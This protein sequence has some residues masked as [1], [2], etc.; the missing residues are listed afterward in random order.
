MTKDAVI[1]VLLITSLVAVMVGVVSHVR[2]VREGGQKGFR[3]APAQELS[4]SGMKAKRN[5]MIGY[6]IFASGITALL[7]ISALW[8]PGGT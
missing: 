4:E 6:L 3:I 5:M 1:V 2:F 7:V 8:G